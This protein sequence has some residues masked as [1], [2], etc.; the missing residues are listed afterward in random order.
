MQ[1]A[2][3]IVKLPQQAAQKK[4]EAEAVEEDRIDA[5]EA[6]LAAALA[7]RSYAPHTEGLDAL[8]DDIGFTAN[9]AHEKR[10]I[11]EQLQVCSPLIAAGLELIESQIKLPINIS[12]HLGPCGTVCNY[13]VC[14][15]NILCG[16]T[17]QPLLKE[18]NRQREYGQCN[19]LSCASFIQAPESKCKDVSCP[20]TEGY[21]TTENCRPPKRIHNPT[22]TVKEDCCQRCDNACDG[23]RCPA[24]QCPE[25]EFPLCAPYKVSLLYSIVHHFLFGF[26]NLTHVYFLI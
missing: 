23:V 4:R 11:E 12:D 2:K 16:K 21:W 15:F 14:G 26:N 25:P 7:L 22:K 18:V 13:A 20:E 1:L 9:P 3:F 19:P 6:K 5:R 17:A 10:G 24:V 8:F